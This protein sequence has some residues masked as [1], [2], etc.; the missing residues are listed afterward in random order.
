MQVQA[1]VFWR[2]QA[3]QTMRHNKLTS[4]GAFRI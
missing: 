4:S 3:L 2:R 1:A